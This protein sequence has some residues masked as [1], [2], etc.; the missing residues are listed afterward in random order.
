M[1]AAR[2]VSCHAPLPE[3]PPCVIM[4]AMIVLPKPL[5][6]RRLALRVTRDAQRALR[7]GHP[8]LY[9]RSITSQSA[10]GAPGD[11]A[12]IF[13]DHRRFLAV[14][15]YD[16]ASPLRVRVL[17]H[18]QPAPID[19]AFLAQR[20]AAAA[21]RRAPLLAASPPTDGYR[22]VYGEGDGLP[23]LVIDRYDRILVIKLY[24]AAWIPWL[25]ALLP[26]LA[27]QQ[28]AQ[29]VVL[30][31]SR[32]VQAQ[33]HALLGLADGVTLAGAPP[34]EPWTF[35]ENGLRF[36]VDVLRGQ[37]TGFFLDQRDNRAR[38]ET[39]AAGRSTLNVFAYTGGFSLYAARGGAPAVTSLD[40][41]AP[42]LAAAV[43]NFSLNRHLPAVAAAQH[44]I[45]VADAFAG[46]KQLAAA[47]QRFGL[48]VV[49]PPAFAKQQ[50][51]IPAALRAYERLARL[52]A[53]VVQPRG[54]LVMASCSSRVSAPEFYAAVRRGAAAAGRTFHEFDHT[55]HP[56]DHPSPFPEGAYLKCL[57]AE[58]T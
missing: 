57:Y 51:E 18:D 45:I 24:S 12:V 27:E 5:P 26:A 36:E 33:P 25:H 22:L 30:R 52:A 6:P 15:L 4:P 31:L 7:A 16:P 40:L 50:S 35:N 55:E 53:G 9:D 14:G 3:F 11:L 34:P 42:A 28:P 48:V 17:Q 19:A 29:W 46:L 1:V 8:W 37:K 54:Q 21:Q 39:L 32:T 43:R 58:V 41:S 38:V 44:D 49:D 2:I 47:G 13:D 23:G 20:L 10:S 56:L